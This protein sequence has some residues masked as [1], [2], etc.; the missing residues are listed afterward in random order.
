[1]QDNQFFDHEA[2]KISL[3]EDL[4]SGQS[5]PR[6]ITG[7]RYWDDRVM[8][9]AGNLITV[10]G[11]TNHGKSSLALS[12]ALSCAGRGIGVSYISLE[13]KFRLMRSRVIGWQAGINPRHLRRNDLRPEQRAWA[14][15][16]GIERLPTLPLVVRT[17]LRRVDDIVKNIH[18]AKELNHQMVVVDYVQAISGGKANDRRIQ[19]GDYCAQIRDAG[20]QVGVTILMVSQI[21][22]RANESDRPTLSMLKEAGELENASDAVVFIFRDD[23]DNRIESW[24]AKH[25]DDFTSSPW[26]LRRDMNWGGALVEVDAMGRAVAPFERHPWEETD[27]DRSS[28]EFGNGRADAPTR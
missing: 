6:L 19:I 9:E 11:A 7:L 14:Q 5:D 28:F 12:V 26:Q 3:A 23:Q 13:D 18:D 25:K 8:M 2:M 21:R 27:D 16:G 10:A 17:D 24:V 22:R 15:G 1:M 4:E 20:D